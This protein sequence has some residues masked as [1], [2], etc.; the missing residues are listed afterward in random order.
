MRKVLAVSAMLFFCGSALAQMPDPPG[1]VRPGEKAVHEAYLFAHIMEGDYGRLYYSVSLDGLHWTLLN[2]GRR[3]FED[4]RGHPD[5][6][7]GHDNRYYLV[8]NRGDDRPDINFWVSEDLIHWNKYS[9]Y[10]PDLKSIPDYPKV[11]LRIGAPKVFYD[12]DSSQYIVTW[13]TTHDLGQ[14]DLPEPYWA[15]QRTIY[16]TS[17]DLKTFSKPP[18]KLF[19]W[20]M[21]TI[22]V[23]IRRVGKS[24]YAI[25]KDER[26]PTLD[27]P[28]GK[29]IRICKSPALTGPYSEPGPPVSPNFR[30]APTLIPSPDGKIWYL[31][32]EQYPGVSYGLSI[33]A[34]LEGPWYQAC[35]AT[36]KKE[37]NKYEVTPKARHGCMMTISRSEYDALLSAFAPLP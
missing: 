14:T 19:K 18:Q 7:R 15:G 1:Q 23:I 32:Y 3:V 30:E 16:A 33:A 10:L 31:Y 35:G 2:G 28:T 20:D 21:A 5:I 6:C 17:K 29:T 37:W 11:L 34:D 8:G 4:Y 27:W 24:Y 25:I 26:Y 9:D 13:H 36:M 22:D 12:K